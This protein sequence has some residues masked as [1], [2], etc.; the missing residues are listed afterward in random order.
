MTQLLHTNSEPI[1]TMSI[2]AKLSGTPTHSI[3][4]YIDK[5]LLLPFKKDTNRHLFSN[6]DIQRLIWIKKRIENNGLNFAGIKTQLALIPCWKITNC[7]SQS[8]QNCDAYTSYDEP[9]WQASKKG[10]EC[11]NKEC[12]L[13][14]VYQSIE[15]NTEVKAILQQFIS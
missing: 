15:A 8:K 5:G 10:K 14:D 7:K 2:A 12:R 6:Y 11:K 9:C 1:Y 3:R 13:C 4:Q